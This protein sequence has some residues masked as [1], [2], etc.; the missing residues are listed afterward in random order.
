VRLFPEGTSTRPTHSVLRRGPDKGWRRGINARRPRV[1]ITARQG[2]PG[3][4]DLRTSR[5]QPSVAA[6]VIAKR[7][8]ARSEPGPPTPRTRLAKPGRLGPRAS[9]TYRLPICDKRS[10][11]AVAPLRSSRDA[12]RADSEASAEREEAAA[13][14][15][16]SRW[17]RSIQSPREAGQGPRRHLTPSVCAVIGRVVSGARRAGATALL[18]PVAPTAEGTTRKS[19]GA[20]PAT[21]GVRRFALCDRSD[22]ASRRMVF[23]SWRSSRF[24]C[25]VACSFP[26]VSSRSADCRCAVANA[27][28]TRLGRR[29]TG[30]KASASRGGLPSLSPRDPTG[31]PIEAIDSDTAGWVTSR[32]VRMNIPAGN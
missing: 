6:R 2:I 31:T 3:S 4:L 26:N 11:R 5:P 19:G 29:P 12:A 30:N 22:R 10:V 7:R 27:T 17:L 15:E 14:T 20:V 28:A 9:C 1:R 32:I 18:G 8:E 23:S 21:D 13:S 16:G 25:R 24:N